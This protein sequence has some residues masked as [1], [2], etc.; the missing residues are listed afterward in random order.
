MPEF[1]QVI[2]VAGFYAQRQATWGGVQL[3]GAEVEGDLP[4]ARGDADGPGGQLQR[5][6]LE[7]RIQCNNILSVRQFTLAGMGVFLQ[8]EPEIRE[9]LASGQLLALLPQ[10]Q[11]PPSRLHI[12]TPRRDVQPAKV[13]YAIWSVSDAGGSA[14]VVHCERMAAGLTA[15]S[16][17]GPVI[18]TNEDAQTY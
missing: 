3:R 11:A 15:P 9:Q 1:M 14:S 4:M 13:R 2:R 17:E 5:V 6:R 10:W 8:P 18:H 7:G 16:H 12:V